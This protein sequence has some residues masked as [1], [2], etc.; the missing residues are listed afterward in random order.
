MLRCFQQKF[1]STKSTIPIG[2]KRMITR[3]DALKLCAGA[4]AFAIG[5]AIKGTS[6]VMP[7]PGEWK[8][9]GEP[10]PRLNALDE[11]MREFMQNQGISAGQLAVS[12]R[13]KLVLNH[14]YTNGEH[15]QVES[16]SLFR[17]ASCSK[18]FTCAAIEALRTSG[19]LDMNSRVFPM[20]DIHEPGVPGQKPPQH[21]NDITVQHLVD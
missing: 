21:I 17:I 14:G 19:K 12:V 3:R 9:T 18:I 11:R 6:A 5:S 7:G 20:L 15:P 13:G 10:A 16:I 4:S 2:G 1:I 8:V